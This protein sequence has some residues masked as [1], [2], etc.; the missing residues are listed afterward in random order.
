MFFADL[1]GRDREPDVAAALAGVQAHVDVLR[2]L[3][4]FPVAV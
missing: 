1:E 2:V 4:S 3:G